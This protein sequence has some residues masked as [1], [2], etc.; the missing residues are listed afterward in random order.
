MEVKE[1]RV[2]KGDIKYK[3]KLTEEQEKAKQLIKDNKVTVLCGA[4][5]T[6]K[7]MVCIATALDLLFTSQIKKIVITRPVVPL[8]SIGFLPGTLEDKLEPY[9]VPIMDNFYRLYDQSKIDSLVL[10]KKIEILPIAFIQGITTN[11]F[12]IVDEAENATEFQIRMI[13]SRLGKEGKI[14]FTGD[15]NQVA[16]QKANQS[17]F[18]KLID[19]AGKID[20]FG[21]M[22]MTTNFR[23]PFVQDFLK[24]Y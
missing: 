10:K 12:L 15:T 3:I 14:V 8:E 7:T 13:G 2:P 16:L 17:G 24:Y 18:K 22:E 20:N 6:S 9:L 11:D 23:D 1:K 19:M 21:V 5:G 4:A